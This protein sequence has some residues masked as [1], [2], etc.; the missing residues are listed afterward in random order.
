MMGA[1]PRPPLANPRLLAL[2]DLVDAVGNDYRDAYSAR[3]EGRSRGPVTAIPDLD[4]ELGGHLC[5]GVHGVHGAPGVGKTAF[6]FQ[7]GA[8]CGV[9]CLFVSCEMGAEDLLLRLTARV[10]EVP[11]SRLREAALSPEEV[12]PMFDR[13]A[14][15]HPELVIADATIGSAPPDWLRS[16]LGVTRRGAAHGLVIIDSVNS[17]AEAVAPD[18]SEYDALNAGMIALRELGQDHRVAVLCTI[19]RNRASM[20]SGGL[21][22]GAGSRRLE[23]A[24]DTVLE[25]SRDPDARLDAAREVTVTLKISKN[26]HGA[27]GRSFPL[28]FN[29]A[30]Q[31]FDLAPF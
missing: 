24:C 7:I 8:E 10:N 20:V 23:Y 4:A 5:V 22:A 13:T 11:L 1:A 19:E 14:Q 26:R 3:R 17:W 9:P 12:L 15:S 21:H 31:R 6:A 30:L 18:V 28:C 25:M 29:G 27:P 16:A 2:C